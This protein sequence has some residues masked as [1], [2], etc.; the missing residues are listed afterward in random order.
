MHEVVL[1]IHVLAATI[2]TGGH[3]VLAVTVLPRALRRGDAS[4]VHG[5]ESG[6]EKIGIP[7]LVLQVLTGFHLAMTRLP[8]ASDWFRFADP[9]STWIPVKFICLLATVGLAAHARLRIL[10]DLTADRLR[11]LAWHIV[12]VTILSVIF[13]IAGVLIRV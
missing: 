1:I 6:Y 4:I 7:A 10:P 12:P 13:V 3:L 2:W 9:A 11:A 5:F 8:D